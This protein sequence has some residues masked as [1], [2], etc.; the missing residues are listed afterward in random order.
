MIAACLLA[1][2]T[3]QVI[4]RL[5]NDEIDVAIALTDPLL[6]GIANGTSEGAYKLV[7][8]YVTSPLNWAVVT[9][10]DSK[11]QN[12]ADLRGTTIGISRAGRFV[13]RPRSYCC[14]EMIICNRI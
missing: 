13:D 8:S 6:A 11:Y 1:G 9:G 3:G 7:G 10:K 12:I 2:G 14:R 4:S 5:R